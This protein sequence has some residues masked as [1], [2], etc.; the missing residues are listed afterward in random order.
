M[1]FRVARNGA[2]WR[3]R[4]GVA[5]GAAHLHR[6]IVDVRH[7][8]LPYFLRR[9]VNEPRKHH[10]IPSMLLSR[11]TVDGT[12]R[13]KLWEFD[14]VKGEWRKSRPRQSGY[15]RDFHRVELPG[16]DPFAVEKFLAESVE[17]PAAPIIR[18]IGDKQIL[19]VDL[20]EW[21]T[22]L[23]FLALLVVRVPNRRDELD[24]FQTRLT[25][26][27]G[28]MAGSRE[29][30]LRSLPKSHPSTRESMI[31]LL[32]G[33]ASAAK[34][35]TTDHVYIMLRVAVDLANYLGER[36]WS[37]L[38][39]PPGSPD[40][41]MSDDPVQVRFIRGG[42]RGHA[43]FGMAETDVTVPV[44]RRCALLGTWD[45]DH[46]AIIDC[47]ERL[48]AKV[49]TRTASTSGRFLWATQR[50][51]VF[52]RDDGALVDERAL[53]AAHKAARERRKRP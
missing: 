27:I 28:Q 16:R 3:G 13:A 40:F 47:S 29:V 52:E 1:T 39:A 53:F 17:D 51:A 46:G 2:H 38:F 7:L 33:T 41:I 15:R 10:F 32:D 43:G 50:T 42:P 45:G 35:S 30:A 37:I 11:F 18:A 25:K 14:L 31:A 23:T 6:S 34:V 5:L 44:H 24:D 48:V 22:L 4:L 36:R 8:I 26:M 9:S 19:P 20:A 12:D 49:N 21:D